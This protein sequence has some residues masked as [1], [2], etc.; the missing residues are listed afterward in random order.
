MDVILEIEAVG[1]SGMC[2]NEKQEQ[3]TACN[4][5]LLRANEVCASLAAG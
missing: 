1:H 5:S 2:L 3:L 4:N